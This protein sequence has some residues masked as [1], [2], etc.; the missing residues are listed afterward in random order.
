METT[1][2]PTIPIHKEAAG[3]TD[4]RFMLTSQRVFGSIALHIL[5]AV[6]AFLVA[7]PLLWL[8]SSSLKTEP[9]MFTRP[10]QWIPAEPQWQNF[11]EG[12]SSKPF[13]RFFA[14]SLIISLGSV[15][16]VLLSCPLVAYGFARMRFWGRGLLFYL[17]LGS[18]MI[19]VQVTII[20]LY[21]IFRELGWLN[22]F[23]PL[24]APSFLAPAFFVFMLR[25]F[26]TSLPRD[27]EEAAYIDGAGFFRTF[28]SIVLPQIRP[29]LASV[30]IFQ[31]M[32]SW[33][34]FFLPLV[35]LSSEQNHTLSLAIANMAGSY[36]TPY[37]HLLP[38]SLLALLPPVVL[39]LFLQRHFIEGI[40]LTGLKQ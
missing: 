7:F 39:F 15:I 26:L 5:V 10:V 8:A 4:S 11:S 37:R 1:N 16:G 24:I 20:P 9:E 30:A 40:T 29:A 14:N 33:N 21:T 3:S 25:Q 38:I 22:T 6:L 27:L 31:F 23:A 12:L 28:W 18:M 36:Y 17:L 35:F 13:G 32:A 34:D 19:P 2:N